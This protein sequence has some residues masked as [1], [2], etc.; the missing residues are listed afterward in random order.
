MDPF[1]NCYNTV[2]III[3]NL[4]N[5]LQIYYI[6]LTD[7]TSPICYAYATHISR[8]KVTVEKF[9]SDVSKPDKLFQ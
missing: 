9:K 3:Y 6:Y 1:D 4:Y 7:Y 8:P 5:Y 2:Y